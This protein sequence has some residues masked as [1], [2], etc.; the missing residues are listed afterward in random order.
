MRAEFAILTFLRGNRGQVSVAAAL[1]V[2]AR[3]LFV[4]T[5]C[6]RGCAFPGPL[7][8]VFALGW[9]RSLKKS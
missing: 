6:A 9:T 4:R 5:L 2:G 3:V 7:E 1:W 8:L